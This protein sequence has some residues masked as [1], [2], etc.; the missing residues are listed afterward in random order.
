MER[1]QY[2][3]TNVELGMLGFMPECFHAEVGPKTAADCGNTHER[4]LWDPPSTSLG[5][6]FV[7][8][9]KYEGY[10][11]DYE[12]VNDRIIHIVF[13]F[14]EG[15]FVKKLWVLAVLML[16]L[17]GCDAA[18][19]FE[20]VWDL[21][22]EP[23]IQPVR[24]VR[25]TLP[26]ESVAPVFSAT[27]S[28]RLYLCDDYTVT[29]ETMIAGDLDATFRAVTGYPQAY[30]TV[31]HTQTSDGKRYECAWV[32]AG[33]GGECVGRT[34]ILD[35]GH[36][37]YAVTV[38]SQAETAGELTGQWQKVLESVTLSTAA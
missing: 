19:T 25:V 21:W 33:E 20:T 18:E 29:V 38:M 35:D 17:S 3:Q 14:Q 1:H 12:Q 32:S 6:H 16:I 7:C 22:E 9:H 11:I 34:V 15:I 30:L 8:K 24:Q 26:D 28:G 37:H 13:S 31:M 27:E 10:R 5:F 23:E 36:Y 2:R 4:R